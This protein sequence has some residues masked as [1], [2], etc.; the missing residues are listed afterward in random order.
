MVRRI[1][2]CVLAAGL[3][4]SVLAGC[5]SKAQE[6]ATPASTAE[7]VK[8]TGTTAAEVKSLDPVTLKI[9]IP[10]D[11]PAEMDAVLAEAEKGMQDSVNAKLDVVF[12]PW[13]DLGNKTQVTLAGGEE[14]DLIFD[15]PWLHM[16]QMIGAGYYEPLDELIRQYGP[17]LYK[18]RPEIMWEANKYDGKIMGVP[19]GVFHHGAGRSF[20]IRKDIRE[21]LGFGP[22]TSY[23]ELEKFLYAVKEKEAGMIPFTTEK[24]APDMSISNVRIERDYDLKAKVTDALGQTLVLYHKNNDGKV[25]NLFDQME[26]KI[27]E[28]I[29]QARK[30]YTDKITNQD[31]MASQGGGD[32]MKAGKAACIVNNDLVNNYTMQDDLQKAIPGASLE[33][34]TLY[35]FEPKANIS[36][37]KQGNFQCVPKVSSNKERAV[38]FLDWANSS[39][40]NY[41]LLAYGIKGTNWEA[42]GDKQFKPVG[43]G[44]SYFPYAWI[45]NPLYERMDARYTKEELDAKVFCTVGDNF[46]PDILTGFSFDSKPVSNEM[47]QWNTLE[48]KYYVLIM[49]GLVD[50]QVYWEK[51]KKEAEAPVKKIQE[52]LQKQIDAFLAAKK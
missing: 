9:M 51:M 34:F 19:L 28:Y 3:L 38:M 27:W 29:L 32:L 2:A 13:A 15:A 7:T 4:V 10:G 49:N 17:N 35:R 46:L 8:N 26:P 43:S 23:D 52:E 39:Q 16:Q 24:H 30:Y 22:I 33:A 31:L 25:Y 42:I 45:W 6:N 37:F 36:N 41:D 44:Y 20:L 50:P 1:L 18:V 11:R 48:T 14:V 47:A 40:E 21:K 12:I 5:G